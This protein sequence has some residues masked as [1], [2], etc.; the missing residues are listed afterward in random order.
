MYKAQS[1][2]LENMPFWRSLL[3]R[4]PPEAPMHSLFIFHTKTWPQ[5]LGFCPISSGLEVGMF[6]INF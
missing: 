3:T 5:V 4:T 6:V 1:Q 2:E